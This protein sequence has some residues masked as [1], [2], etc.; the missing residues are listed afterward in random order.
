MMLYRVRQRVAEERRPTHRD[1][2]VQD[3]SPVGAQDG[4]PGQLPV[5]VIKMVEDML[6][7]G[8]RRVG[9]ALTEGAL[10]LPTRKADLMAIVS[11]DPRASL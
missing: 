1:V 8:G 7:K 2:E 6:Q 10:T 4:N 11:G 9:N 3:E 5:G